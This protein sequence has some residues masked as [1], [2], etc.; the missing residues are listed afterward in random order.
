M[1]AI[2]K[3]LGFE[4]EKEFHSLV[5]AADLST[6]EKETAFKKWQSEDGSK[7]GLLK[8]SAPKHHRSCPVNGAVCLCGLY[9]DKDR[10]LNF[11]RFVQHAHSGHH[12]EHGCTSGICAE[13]DKLRKDGIL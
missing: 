9:R 5:A 6:P 12:I 11:V 7:E 10:L 4:S 3:Q 8:L 13:I 1:E 2:V